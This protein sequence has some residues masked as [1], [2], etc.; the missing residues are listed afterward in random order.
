MNTTKTLALVAMAAVSLGTGSAMAQSRVV[1][2]GSYN[3]VPPAR[4]A[5]QANAPTAAGTQ[6]TTVQY[7]SSDHYSSGVPGFNTD[8]IAGGF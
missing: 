1:T 4:T 2:P 8:P 5:S 6:D 7:G 3:Y